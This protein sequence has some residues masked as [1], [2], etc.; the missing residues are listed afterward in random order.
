MCSYIENGIV[1]QIDS[2]YA[3]IQIKS[4]VEIIGENQLGFTKDE[5]GLY[6]IRSGGAMSMFLSG[7][8]EII[9]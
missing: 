2:H 4:I 6:S 5:V 3:R 9:L 1:R 7:V 8:S